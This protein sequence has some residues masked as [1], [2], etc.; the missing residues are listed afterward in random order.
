[1]QMHPGGEV[2]KGF[3]SRRPPFR[4]LSRRLFSLAPFIDANELVFTPVETNI[5]PASAGPDFDSCAIERPAGRRKSA[6]FHHPFVKRP[7]IQY[8][9]RSFVVLT[10]GR[11]RV[12]KRSLTSRFMFIISSY[13]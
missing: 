6:R 12:S 2:A 1:M 5:T 8:T 13:M 4:I 3:K 7:A 9:F 11:E 10:F